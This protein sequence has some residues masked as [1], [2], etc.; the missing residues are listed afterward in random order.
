MLFSFCNNHTYPNYTYLKASFIKIICVFVQNVIFCLHIMY[1]VKPRTDNLWIFIQSSL[2]IRLATVRS[3]PD[4][5]LICRP[6]KKTGPY[7]LANWDRSPDRKIQSS[8]G[9]KTVRS[10]AQMETDKKDQ[11]VRS[12]TL[13]LQSSPVPEKAGLDRTVQSKTRLQKW[14]SQF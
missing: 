4:R 3:G 11:T 12:D 6:L 10:Q 1:K 2:V 13:G 9:K 14:E 8:L 5:S 7:G